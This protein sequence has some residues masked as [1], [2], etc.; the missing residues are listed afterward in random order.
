MI[1][2]RM[3]AP[4]VV[5]ALAVYGG[6]SGLAETAFDRN[7]PDAVVIV[8]IE[9]NKSTTLAFKRYD[10]A[11][12]FLAGKD[13]GSN[14]FVAR[15]SLLGGDRVTAHRVTPGTYALFEISIPAPVHDPGRGGTSTVPMYTRFGSRDPF[16]PGGGK[17]HD[18]APTFTVAA[19]EIVY[20]GTFV[21]STRYA[22]GPSEVST[23]IDEQAAH[24]ALAR[25]PNVKGEMQTRRPQPAGHAKGG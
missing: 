23:R 21:V 7:S 22:M 24:Q 8:G 25:N 15:Y 3:L 18:D 11:T 19:G 13:G 4:A 1:R 10:P 2:V 9:S 14:G 17:V 16:M 5:V 6:G 12:H 20:V